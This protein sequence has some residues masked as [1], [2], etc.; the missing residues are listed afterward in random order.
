LAD[1]QSGRELRDDAQLA[2]VAHRPQL[3]PDADRPASSD[4]H[5]REI[6][7]KVVGLPGVGVQ[8]PQDLEDALRNHGDDGRSDR[9]GFGAPQGVLELAAQCDHGRVAF[10]I[11]SVAALADDK[12]GRYFRGSSGHPD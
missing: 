8:V 1:S 10:R 3:I 2:S 9:I 6:D 4:V 7:E 11:L 12:L 5:S